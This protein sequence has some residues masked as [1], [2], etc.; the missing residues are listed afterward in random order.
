MHCYPQGR[1][2][3]H[4][5]YCSTSSHLWPPLPALAPARTH[6]GIEDYLPAGINLADYDVSKMDASIKV[7]Y[8][9]RLVGLSWFGVLDT[10]G[11]S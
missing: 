3:A 2:P 5:Y 6:T 9:G 4:R 1:A 8:V 11:A 10:V 7:S